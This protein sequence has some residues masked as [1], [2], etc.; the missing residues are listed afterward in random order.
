MVFSFYKNCSDIFV[1]TV[2]G[3]TAHGVSEDTCIGGCCASTGACLDYTYSVCNSS[4]GTF[5][6]PATSCSTAYCPAS[7]IT[8]TCPPSMFTNASRFEI[9][10]NGTVTATN[11]TLNFGGVGLIIIYFII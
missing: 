11:A 4:G 8:G 9:Y 10:A 2:E 7:N 1:W 5:L 3:Q 6:G